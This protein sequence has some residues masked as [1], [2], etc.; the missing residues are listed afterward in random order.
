MAVRIVPLHASELAE[1]ATVPISFLAT[2]RVRPTLGS[3]DVAEPHEPLPTPFVKDYDRLPEMSPVKWS[4]RF[5]RGDWGIFVARQNDVVVGGAAVAPSTEAGLADAPLGKAAILWDLRVAPAVRGQHVGTM[6]FRAAKQWAADHSHAT[7][8]A[9]TQDINVAA[10]R[11][12]RAMGCILIA[13]EPDA[14]PEFPSEAR[15][16]WCCDLRA[17]HLNG[18]GNL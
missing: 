10:C 16:I 12:Y 1:Y 14:Y 13:C 18:E 9:E 11:F 5:R 17:D 7:L 6:L 8:V 2:H 4:S 3:N 15:L